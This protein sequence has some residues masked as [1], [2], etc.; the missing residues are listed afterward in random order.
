MTRSL[1]LATLAFLLAAPSRAAPV[2]LDLWPACDRPHRPATIRSTDL[3]A[4]IVQGIQRSPTLRDLVHRLVHSDVVVYV[5]ADPRPVHG[6]DGRLTF[7]AAHGGSR[8]LVIRLRQTGSRP[9]EIAV[10]GHEL[11]HAVEVAGAPEIV[12]A[13]TLAKAFLGFG[14][15]SRSEGGRTVALDTRAAVLKGREVLREL[16]RQGDISAE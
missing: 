1:M 16:R 13:P 12:D 4:L 7:L 2:S 14:Y 15:V 3:D 5:Q 8:Y 9:H 11:Q 6:V 10:L